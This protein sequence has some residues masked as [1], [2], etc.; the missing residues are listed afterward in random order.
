MVLTSTP[1]KCGCG[2]PATTSNCGYAYACYYR[3]YRAGKPESGPPPASKGAA[4]TA[5]LKEDIQWLADASDSHAEIAHRLGVSVQTVRRYLKADAPPVVCA[6]ADCDD[7]TQ[8]RWCERHRDYKQTYREARATGL[9]RQQAAAYVGLRWRS[10]YRWEPGEP[11][12]GRPRKHPRPVGMTAVNPA[13]PVDI[14]RDEG[15]ASVPPRASRPA[16]P[17]G[18]GPASPSALRPGGEASDSGVGADGGGTASAPALT[19]TGGT[20]GARGGSAAAPG[21]ARPA[22]PPP[23]TPE[24]A[25]WIREFAW[26]AQ[27]RTAAFQGFFTRCDCAGFDV[28]CKRGRHHFCHLVPDLVHPYALLNAGEP[29]QQRVWTAVSCRWVC[30]CGCHTA[31]AQLDLF[32]EAT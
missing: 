20:A 11:G 16:S 24:R 32:A 29:T 30:S 4:A 8:S 27:M 15:N 26:T 1:C 9:N 12:Q 28:A 10:T 19:R 18:V 6:V 31:P 21:A 13:L 25:V 23:L 14:R 17:S 7:L 3:W 2:N 22:E 5:A